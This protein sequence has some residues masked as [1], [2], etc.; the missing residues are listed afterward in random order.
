MDTNEVLSLS[1][2]LSMECDTI[3]VL[4]LMTKNQVACFIKQ[5][6]RGEKRVLLRYVEVWW[7]YKRAVQ[8]WPPILPIR[9]CERAVQ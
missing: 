2:F 7:Q 3:E 9:E 8:A 1:V 6:Q 5:V 4:S